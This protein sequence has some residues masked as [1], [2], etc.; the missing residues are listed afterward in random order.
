MRKYEKPGIKSCSDAD[1]GYTISECA[2]VEPQVASETE[3]NS[4]DNCKINNDNQI[5]NVAR[6]TTTIVK[7]DHDSTNESSNI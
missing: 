3:G 4:V 5:Y 7:Y 2:S 1:I 6:T